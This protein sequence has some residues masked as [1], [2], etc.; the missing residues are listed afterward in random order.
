MDKA[1]RL[2][3]TVQKDPGSFRDRSGYVWH[4]EDRIFRTVA[5][6]V[7]PQFQQVLASPFIQ[8]RMEQAD[9]VQ[10]EVIDAAIPGLGAEGGMVLEHQKIPFISYP[11]EWTFGA[12]KDAALLHLDLLLDGLEHGLTMSD[13]TA[14]NIQFLGSRPVFIDTLSFRP[15]KEGEFWPGYRQFCEQFLNPLLLASA[16][17]IPVH[18]WYRGSV[19]GIPS[20]AIAELLPLRRKLSLSAFSH[21]VLPVWLERRAAK[22]MRAHYDQGRAPNR[23]RALPKG[24]F[25]ALLAQLRDWIAG[26][27]PAK[28]KTF[29]WAGYDAFHTYSSPE[30]KVKRDAV[31]AFLSARPASRVVDV[32]CNT[33]KYSTAA[34]EAGAASVVGFEFDPYAA[35]RAFAFSRQNGL[36]FFPV[37]MDGANQS[38]SQGWNQQERAGLAQRAKFDVLIALAV[39]HHLA[40]GRNIPLAEVVRWLTSLAPCGVI[41]FIP[42]SD[43]TIASMLASRKDIFDDYSQEI[44][45]SAIASSARIVDVVETSSEGRKLYFYEGGFIR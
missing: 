5:P 27:S 31:S 13:A 44:F 32:G 20:D 39:E 38:P 37:V 43:T 28:K 1:F 33:G 7:A 12:L 29:T 21:V 10:T 34:L 40:I 26:L 36:N 6:S 23:E 22:N 2:A 19:E 4:F 11:Y 45:E 9:I 8:K 3:S 14:Y 30:E 41:E 35:D 16:F 17:A 42:K 18:H 25:R 24:S 15:Y